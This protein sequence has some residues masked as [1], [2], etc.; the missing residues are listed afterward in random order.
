MSQPDFGGVGRRRF[1][2]F[3]G[4]S[5]WGWGNDCNPQVLLLTLAQHSKH[6]ISVASPNAVL[7]A[8][9]PPERFATPL[10]SYAKLNLQFGSRSTPGAGCHPHDH[11]HPQSHLGPVITSSDHWWGASTS[12]FFSHLYHRL[13]L[14]RHPRGDRPQ[15]LRPVL[16]PRRLGLHRRDGRGRHRP[17]HQHR[18]RRLLCSRRGAQVQ[19]RDQNRELGTDYLPP[20]TPTADIFFSVHRRGPVRTVRW[21][22]RRTLRRG[23]ERQGVQVPPQAMSGLFPW[24][25]AAYP[26]YEAAPG[27]RPRSVLF[28]TGQMFEPLDP[29]QF[30]QP[31]ELSPG[32]H[33]RLPL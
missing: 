14:L 6:V 32:P 5:G 3:D 17:Y 23:M 18:H 30:S 27:P 13:P 11:R 9:F 12:N 8:P 15:P 10:L 1:P 28:H 25:E 4:A 29:T 20:P 19:S 26:I 16:R 31:K 21:R 2:E 22:V 7:P 24:H 33:A